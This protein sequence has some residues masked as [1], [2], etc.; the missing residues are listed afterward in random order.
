[1]RQATR[2]MQELLLCNRLIKNL[3]DTLMA[4]VRGHDKARGKFRTIQ[5]YIGVY[6]RP[7]EEARFFPSRR[8]PSNRAWLA[9]KSTCTNKRT[10]C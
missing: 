3:H 1:M 9:G 4:D 2:E 5:N 10:T 8:T 6:G 7:V